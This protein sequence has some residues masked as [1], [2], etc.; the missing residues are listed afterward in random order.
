MDRQTYLND[1]NFPLQLTFK[2]A[3]EIEYAL[4]FES[5]DDTINAIGHKALKTAH[6]PDDSLHQ[7]LKTLTKRYELLEATMQKTH[8]AQP[9]SY[10]SGEHGGYGNQ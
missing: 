9:T 7:T 4:E 3:I 6:T 5:Q 10:S 1:K 2:N 8:K